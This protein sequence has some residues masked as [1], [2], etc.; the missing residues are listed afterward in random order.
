VS[1][2]VIEFKGVSCVWV[3]DQWVRGVNAYIMP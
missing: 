1:V 2:F 3:C